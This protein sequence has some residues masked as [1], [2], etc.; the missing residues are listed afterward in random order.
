MD[1]RN[2]LDVVELAPYVSE[3]NIIRTRIE[4]ESCYLIALSEAHIIRSLKNQ[5]RKKLASFGANISL[6]DAR[7]I[8]RIEEETQHDVKA[9]ELAFRIMLEETSLADIVEM[10]HLGLTSEDVNNLSYRL[11]LKR[12]NEAVFVPELE[13]LIDELIKVDNRT[14]AAPKISRTHG[15]AA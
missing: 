14:K 15:L 9:M 7:R 8:K 6:S 10:V 2:R 13:G 1:G 3:F 4:V 12:A 11:I 5:E